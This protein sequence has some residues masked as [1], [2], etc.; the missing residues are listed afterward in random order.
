MDSER[1]GSNNNEHRASE[2]VTG[3]SKV[4]VCKAARNSFTKR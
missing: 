4:S 1:D 3:E 2:R